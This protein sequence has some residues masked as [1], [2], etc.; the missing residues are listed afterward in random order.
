MSKPIM[1]WFSG[2]ILLL[3]IIAITILLRNIS[4]E[5]VPEAPEVESVEPVEA[6]PAEPE[7]EVEPE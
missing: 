5:P 1:K 3:A 6:V 7:P 4:P 2:I